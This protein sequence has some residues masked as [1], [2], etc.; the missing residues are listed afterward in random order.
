MKVLLIDL[1]RR[2]SDVYGR[3]IARSLMER[4]ELKALISKYA[5]SL[6]QWRTDISNLYEIDTYTSGCEFVKRTITRE[7]IV[8]ARA[9]IA[10]EAP[11]IV[12]YPMLSPWTPLIHSQNQD[13]KLVST[14]HDL[15]L[16][17]GEWNPII[18]YMTAKSIRQSDGI[19]FLNGYS[20]EQFLQRRK[21]KLTTSIPLGAFD[22]YLTDEGDRYSTESGR[23]NILFL[24][25]ILKY[26][27]LGVLLKAYPII[28]ESVPDSRLI[29]A[30]QGNLA[31]YSKQ[32]RLCA[33]VEIHNKYLSNIE[34]NA[35]MKTADVL[36]LPYIDASQSAILTI[37]QVYGVPV[38]ATN[39]CGLNE[40]IQ[41]GITGVLV[42]P[43]NSEELAN[44]C[45]KLLR[46]PNLREVLSRNE[47]EYVDC[48]LGWDTIAREIVSFFEKVLRT[49]EVA[50]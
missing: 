36:V 32:I 50:S 16:H 11:D 2:S 7:A 25:R 18:N 31:A 13:A 33:D 30:G 15:K 23:A 4:V 10:K 48:S 3:S 38:I 9:I 8:E 12:Y 41:D 42:A 46:D 22:S 43:G 27:G 44:E 19:I 45:V 6:Q 34:I 17:Q 49:S 37:G 47:I 26:K 28:K 35:L 24:G 1:N 40:Q 20:E 29:I 14:I 5:G 39:I 21:D